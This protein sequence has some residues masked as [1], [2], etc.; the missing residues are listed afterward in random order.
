MKGKGFQ[1]FLGAEA[2]FFLVLYWVASGETPWVADVMAFPF[3]QIGAGLRALSLSG[4][5]GNA[6][7][8][9]LYL[10]LSLIPV[11]VLI[12]LGRKRAL[13]P[14]DVLLVILSIL[15]FAVFYF[16]INPGQIP[17]LFLAGQ[18]DRSVEQSLF[19]GT[20]YAL[21]FS[22]LVLRALRHFM[23]ADREKLQDY[24][25][26]LLRLLA[27][28]FVFLAFGPA[29]QVFLEEL[30][31]LQT[32]GLGFALH[33]GSNTFFVFLQYLA[34]MLPHLLT[35]MV[36]LAALDLMAAMKTDRYSQAAAD[37]AHHVSRL[38][39]VSLAVSL[40]VT[41]AMNLLQLLFLGQ[42]QSVR[43]QV[44]IPILSVAFLL[45]VLLVVQFIRENRQLK[46][47]NDLFI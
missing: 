47:D 6:V 25:A 14:E 10:L 13:A 22:Y 9:L 40:L 27:V 36:T 31:A 35:V 16:M 46:E 5:G 32:D 23:V 39:G 42:L 4:S 15:L 11:A 7:A 12:F 26:I 20:A 41:V 33:N 43:I 38:C 8:I 45:A 37:K 28:Y 18:E 1:L 21:I 24:L 19:S 44:V 30:A 17:S 2:I 34:N 3:A 29:F